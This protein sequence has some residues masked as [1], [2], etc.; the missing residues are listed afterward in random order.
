MAKK[1]SVEQQI[2][3]YK[4]EIEKELVHWHDEYENGCNDPFWPDGVNLNLVRNHVLYYRRQIRELMQCPVQMSLFGDVCDEF[5]CEIP[6]EVD[7]DYMAKP[8]P[9]AYFET[10]EVS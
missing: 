9:C 8:R 2:E 5:D 6:P 3:N 4:K 10:Q 1:L 7:Q